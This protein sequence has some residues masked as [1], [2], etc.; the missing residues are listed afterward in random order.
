[1]AE[2]Q[3]DREIEALA[4]RVAGQEVA[5][6]LD[7]VR[8]VVAPPDVTPLPGSDPSLLGVAAVR[9]TIVPVLDL[10]RRLF[11]TAAAADGRLILVGEPGS[12][13]PLGLLVDAVPGLLSGTAAPRR[14]RA[15][16]ALSAALAPRVLR[17]ADRSLPLLD[18]A[19]VVELPRAR[20]AR[21]P[22]AGA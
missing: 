12:G 20:S 2:T 19:A 11:A 5:L 18:L 16:D 7:A 15:A 1:M 14:R 21:P 3:G 9:G 8:E 4:I 10:S 13:E 6:P 17:A 22:A